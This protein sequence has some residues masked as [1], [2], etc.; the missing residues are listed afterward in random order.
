M[1]PGETAL[2]T[3]LRELAEETGIRLP[4][5]DASATHTVRAGRLARYRVTCFVVEIED[6]PDPVPGPE[7][8]ARWVALRDAV[9]LRP[10]TIGTRRVLRELT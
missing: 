5:R 10:M 2:E 3:G 1:L 4:I 8:D 9:D 7:L 6:A